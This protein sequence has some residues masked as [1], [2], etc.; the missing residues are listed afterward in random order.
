MVFRRSCGVLLALVLVGALTEVGPVAA[1]RMAAPASASPDGL[2]GMWANQALNRLSLEEKVGQLFVV[3]VWGKT[4][5][6]VNPTNRANYGV[7]TP[8]EVV[9]RYNVGGVIYFN[10]ATTDNVD[11]PRQVAQL[12]NG[13]QL[14]AIQSGLHLPLII[15]IDQEGGNVTRLE[16]PATEFPGNMSI[17]AGRSA[18]DAR[19][20]ATINAR[21]LRAMGINQNFAPVADV[22]SNPLNPVIGA[23]SFSS[24]PDVASTLVQAEI[25]GY[26]NS[27]RTSETVSSAAKHFPGH[28]DAATDSHTSLPIINRTE[29]QWRAIDLPP[30]RAAIASGVDAIMTAHIEMPNLEP[31]GLPAT[32]SHHILTDLLRDELGYRGVIVTDALGMGGAN[33]LPPEEIPV[34]ALEAGADELLMPPDLNLAK[35]AVLNAVHSGR[36]SESRINQSVLRI[37]LQKFKRAILFSPFVDVNKVDTTV[38]TAA[39]LA[40]VQRI[41]D[42]TVTVLRNDAGVL[43]AR[44]KPNSVLVT[45]IGDTVFSARSPQWLADSLTRRGITATAMPAG[46]VPSEATATAIATAAQNADL[47]IDLTNSLGTRASHRNLLTKLQATG[48]PIVAVATQIP[49]DAGFIDN[50]TWIATYS[51]RAVSMESLAKVLLGEISPRGKLP[52]DIPVNYTTPPTTYPFDTGLTW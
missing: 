37:L 33:V 31:S 29:E 28:G 48:K 8:A 23:R 13:L 47:V 12:S 51:W 2:A 9:Q 24:H 6:E 46:S 41:S 49:Y 4:A 3:S 50:P 25:Q 20:L 11:S 30:F 1:E 15:A 18:A 43:P 40:E 10:N 27:G 52:V 7:D 21:E 14:A 34:R 44:T 5:D 35:T 19:S 26:Q 42:G 16:S 36:L 32:M 17:G 39:N 45:G 38:G 22:N